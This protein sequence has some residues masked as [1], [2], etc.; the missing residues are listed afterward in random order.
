MCARACVYVCVY[1]CVCR[2]GN[3]MAPVV[4]LQFVQTTV[5]SQ[6]T[7]T[8]THFPQDDDDEFGFDDSDDEKAKAKVPTSS[9]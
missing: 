6:C 7:L 3:R 8:C 5:M 2:G 1:V 9:S 4:V